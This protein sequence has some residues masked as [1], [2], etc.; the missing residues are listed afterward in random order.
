MRDD[1]LSKR[2]KRQGGRKSNQASNENIEE[3]TQDNKNNGYQNQA[4]QGDDNDVGEQTLRQSDSPT[5]A[6]TPDSVK[7]AVTRKHREKS[8]ELR[9]KLPSDTDP[10]EVKREIGVVR[11]KI[12]NILKSKLNEQLSLVRSEKD[13]DENEN[14]GDMLGSSRK[15]DL[16]LDLTSATAD[17]NASQTQ[18]KMSTSLRI[19]QLMK[20]IKVISWFSFCRISK[21]QIFLFT[22]TR[23]KQEQLP[24]DWR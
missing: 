2:K 21:Y 4:F 10:N 14:E 5:G 3:P 22:E 7:D 18:P 6:R 11:D 1:I 16:K 8:R 9:N 15:N 20:Q 23:R 19:E 13:E 17:L 24:I 12:Q